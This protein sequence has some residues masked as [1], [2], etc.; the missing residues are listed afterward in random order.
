MHPLAVKIGREAWLAQ[1]LVRLVRFAARKV[2]RT[3]HFSTVAIGRIDASPCVT[4]RDAPVQR[5]RNEP[6]S[7]GTGHEM[8]AC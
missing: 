3:V 1:M 8:F 5:E 4:G 2:V 6:E 7:H